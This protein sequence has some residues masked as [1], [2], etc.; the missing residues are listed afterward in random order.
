VAAGTPAALG[1]LAHGPASVPTNARFAGGLEAVK[2]RMKTVKNI[3]KITSAMK[4]V[5][6]SKLRKAQVDME[7]SRQMVA[8][9]VRIV[10]DHPATEGR[11]NLTV[12]LTSDRGLCGGINSSVARF[13]RATFAAAGG[14]D[15]SYVVLGEKGRAQLQRSEGSRITQ[16]I[17]D[18]AKAR[19]T[20]TTASQVAEEL[21]KRE[22]ETVRIVFNKFQSAISFRPTIATALSGPM[23]LD[24]L[25]SKG[26]MDKY[27]I[28]GPEDELELAQNL[29]E[30]QL[31]TVLFNGL[32][33]NQTS[34]NASR[35]Q[36]MENSTKNASEM[37]EKLS[38]TYNR[39]R[40]A[41]IT[42]EL[43]EIISGASALE[44]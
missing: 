19:L 30:F 35:M 6:A 4:L 38:I 31:A 20:F 34:E 7:K 26:T 9:F 36:A 29:A 5:A 3:K 32:L 17:G 8:P 15:A 23:L 42:T 44:G 33:E 1:E 10:G 41:S 18:L 11:K 43:I 28:E 39:A 13:S 27:E 2:N 21:M 12:P 40:Q 25:Q 16:T 37:I 14:E 22:P 24:V